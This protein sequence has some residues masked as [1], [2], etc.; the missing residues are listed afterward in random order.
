[1]KFLSSIQLDFA[2]RAVLLRS[3]GGELKILL[4]N[5]DIYQQAISCP[6]PL[7]YLRGE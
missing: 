4:I 3:L 1:M 5:H 7:E 6:H 2:I